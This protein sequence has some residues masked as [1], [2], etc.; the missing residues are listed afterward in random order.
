MFKAVVA[1]LST[2]QQ[3]ETIVGELKTAG[4]PAGEISVLF[5]QV[6]DSAGFAAEMATKVPE[7]AALGAVTVGSAG[8]WLGGGLGLLAGLGAIAIPGIGAF[9]A[10][11][12]LL[13]LLSGAAVGATVGV[14]VGS[15]TGVLITL[16]IPELQAQQYEG[17]VS[18]GHI[19]ISV[20]SE[21]AQRQLLAAAVLRRLGAENI[22]SAVESLEPM[23]TPATEPSMTLR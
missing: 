21:D 13:S 9:L 23:R 11:G 5:P 8:M 2:Q 20:H 6:S 1:T 15:L 12:P 18:N 22:C 7:G 3:A 17:M 4:F 19:L 14:T 10:V 16:G